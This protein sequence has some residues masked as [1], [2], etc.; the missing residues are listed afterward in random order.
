MSLLNI[1]GL[2][3]VVGFFYARYIT[4]LLERRDDLTLKMW[5]GY[6]VFWPAITIAIAGICAFDALDDFGARVRKSDTAKALLFA[7][8]P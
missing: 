4:P 2:Y 3:A 5:F 1:L 7:R 6:F 8:P